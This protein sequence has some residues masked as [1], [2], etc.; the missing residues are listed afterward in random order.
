MR[1]SLVLAFVLSGLRSD[2]LTTRFPTAP[3]RVRTATPD[4]TGQTPTRAWRMLDFAEAHS[5]T[6]ASLR[7]RTGSHQMDSEPQ[8]ECHPGAPQETGGYSPGILRFVLLLALCA[9]LASHAFG[10][11]ATSSSR[12]SLPRA[13]YD[14]TEEIT[15]Q[16]NVSCSFSVDGQDVAYGRIVRILVSP[17]AHHI[18]CDPD[19]YIAKEDYVQPP[20]SS[21]YTFRFTFLME[22][23]EVVATPATTNVQPQATYQV[24]ADANR[25]SISASVS[26]R[27]F[28]MEVRGDDAAEPGRLV[29]S[30]RSTLTDQG[31]MS[32]VA[33]EESHDELWAGVEETVLNPSERRA[34]ELSWANQQAFDWALALEVV[35]VDR[36][37]IEVSIAVY[38]PMSTELLRMFVESV[39]TGGDLRPVVRLLGR[40]FVDWVEEQ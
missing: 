22:D 16:S 24:A 35:E 17:S 31:G 36:G 18:G 26:P 15:L 30:L 38:D 34:V 25:G 6:F 12:S 32:I 39:G 7:M 3:R 8:K 23:Q 5:A 2:S 9:L 13:S 11:A 27:I 4:F 14:A 1:V 20:Y 19:G 29:S 21:G 28:I 40:D 37:L 10:C 33:Y